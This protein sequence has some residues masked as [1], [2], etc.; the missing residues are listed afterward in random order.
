MFK[1]FLLRAASSSTTTTTAVSASATTTTVVASSSTSSISV[2]DDS[3]VVDD[4]AS[5]VVD[6]NAADLGSPSAAGKSN[7]SG[8]LTVPLSERQ[9]MAMLM[10]ISKAD[11]PTTGGDAVVAADVPQSPHTVFSSG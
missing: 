7:G 3:G 8:R 1:D 11:T 6:L 2:P 5:G 4:S 9:Q 10:Q